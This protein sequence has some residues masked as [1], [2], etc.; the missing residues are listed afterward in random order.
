MFYL[1]LILIFVCSLYVYIKSRYNFWTNNGF[2]SAKAKFLQGN[3]DGVG[4]TRSTAQALKDLYDEYRGKEDFIG[5]YL[6][7]SPGLLIINPELAKLILVKDFQS[8][9]DRG[10]Y[11]NKKDDPMSASLVRIECDLNFL[12]QYFYQKKLIADNARG[13]LETDANENNADF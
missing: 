4:R 12:K 6:L 7:I 8:F 5:M 1:T 11:Y 10:M 9:S 2:P 3:I 13:R